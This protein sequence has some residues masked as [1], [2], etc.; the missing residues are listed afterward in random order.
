VQR[1]HSGKIDV[2]RNVIQSIRRTAATAL[3]CSRREAVVILRTMSQGP[4]STCGAQSGADAEHYRSRK[5]YK[6]QGRSRRSHSGSDTPGD[7]RRHWRVDRVHKPKSPAHEVMG[8][9]EAEKAG[10][11]CDNDL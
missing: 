2:S 6:W 11:E 7:D 9:N 8:E 10:G 1:H 5:R 4:R 3:N